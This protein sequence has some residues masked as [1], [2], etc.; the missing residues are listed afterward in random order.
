MCSFF[1]REL[2]LTW[3]LTIVPS[4]GGQGEGLREDDKQSVPSFR[5]T[6]L[7]TVKFKM[8]QV[9]D[10]LLPKDFILSIK[11]PHRV[12]GWRTYF[13]PSCGT[14]FQGG[15]DTTR[16]LLLCLHTVTPCDPLTLPEFLSESSFRNKTERGREDRG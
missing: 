11:G 10:T 15:P 5:R 13:L 7:A 3:S 1:D 2:L 9:M 12:L 16:S 14:G 6:T 4:H 8:L